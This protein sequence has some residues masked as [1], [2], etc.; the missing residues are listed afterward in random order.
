MSGLQVGIFVAALD[1]TLVAVA[2]LSI[3]RDLGGTSL[4]AWI[5]AGYTVAATIAAP[6][7]G[8]LSDIY[9][10]QR[11]MSIAIIVYMVACIGCMFAQ[12]MPQLLC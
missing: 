11:L 12:S 7:Y 9:G 4:L 1:S 10:R 3:A 5:V 8:S 6:V 2:L